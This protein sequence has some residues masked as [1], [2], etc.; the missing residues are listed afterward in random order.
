MAIHD[1]VIANQTGANT[2]SDLNNVFAAIVSNNSSA[3]APTTTYA[4]MFWADTAN[5][6]LKQRNAANSGWINVYT[7]STGAVDKTSATGSAVL[8]AGTTAQRDGSLGASHAGYLRFNTTDTSAEVWDGSAW[9]AV[10]GGNSTDKGMYEH[11]SRI[12]ANYS[13]TD[14]NNAVSGSPITISSG[15]S[16]TIP[17]NSSWSIV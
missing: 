2:R 1:Y 15:I 17:A 13:I 10:G 7:L 5:D 12:T 14:W 11:E 8:P 6:L 9:S 3:T 16:V 4:Y